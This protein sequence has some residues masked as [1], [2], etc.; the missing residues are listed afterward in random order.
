MARIAKSGPCLCLM[1]IGLPFAC[2][3]S[4]P[5]LPTTAMTATTDDCGW[6]VSFDQ[7]LK[8]GNV[9]LIGEMHGTN[10]A[11]LFVE[12]AACRDILLKMPIAVAL[13]I[14]ASVVSDA[15]LH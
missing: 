2:S 8:A 11:S 13:E 15:Q 5:A 9:V 10:E 14:P 3:H 7:A 1:S 4:A 12:A 6:L